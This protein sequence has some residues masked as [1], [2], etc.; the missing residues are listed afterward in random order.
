MKKSRTQGGKF[1][2]HWKGEGPV[3]RESSPLF[4]QKGQG[5]EEK[6]IGSKLDVDGCRIWSF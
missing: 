6:R 1:L 5:E 4:Y 3:G 2:A